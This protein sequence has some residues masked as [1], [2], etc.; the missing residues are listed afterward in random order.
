MSVVIYRECHYISH[1][2]H[3]VR[4]QRN[5]LIASLSASITVLSCWLYD[6]VL[7]R[8]DEGPAISRRANPRALFKQL[9][10]VLLP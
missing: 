7:G 8:C 1:I 9:S 5:G 2:W 10:E 6:R 3:N 4:Q